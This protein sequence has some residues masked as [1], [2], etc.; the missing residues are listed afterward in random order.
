MAGRYVRKVCRR[1]R[2][3]VGCW[4]VEQE[5][6]SSLMAGRYI[7]RVKIKSWLLGGRAGKDLVIDG[8]KVC[9]RGEEQVWAAG[10]ESG[11]SS[12]H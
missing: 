12:R 8:R 5:K 3:R 7:D 2:S 4:E 9:R 11:E 10:R 1:C 6:I